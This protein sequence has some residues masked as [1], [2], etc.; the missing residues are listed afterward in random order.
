M[1]K[2]II[3]TLAVLPIYAQDESVVVSVTRIYLK[4][5]ISFPQVYIM[6]LDGSGRRQLTRDACEKGIVAISADGKSVAYVEI[7]DR[8]QSVVTIDSK[9][10]KETRRFPLKE[11]FRVT[12]LCWD[13][14]KVK[15]EVTD[16]KNRLDCTIDTKT[17]ETIAA[18]SVG[19]GCKFCGL[20]KRVAAGEF[21][22]ACS[23]QDGAHEMKLSLKPE[24]EHDCAGCPESLTFTSKGGNSISVQPPPDSCEILSEFKWNSSGTKAIVVFM[25]HGA[26]SWFT[27][28]YT[29]G[30]QTGKWSPKCDSVEDARWIPGKDAY[31]G[32]QGCKMTK[33]FQTIK[34]EI[35]VWANDLVVVDGTT[36]ESKPLIAETGITYDYDLAILKK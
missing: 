7:N 24:A 28:A 15:A 2:A 19:G 12:E 18:I 36:S 22:S 33:K 21:D 26:S 9:A 16:E 17:G 20:H 25:D 11:G 5:G 34:R 1:K 30:T 27:S 35:Y 13:R 32:V 8:M 4:S 14:N 10:G 31:L 29:I 6:K 23:T 3:L